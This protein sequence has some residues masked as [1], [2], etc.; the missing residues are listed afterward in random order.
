MKTITT[1]ELKKG[2]KITLRCG[3]NATMEDNKKGNIR[4]A[5]V[6]GI[7]TEMGSIYM[8]DVVLAYKGDETLCVVPTPSQKKLKQAIGSIF[9]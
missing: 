6:E 4:M 7:Y 8:S 9:G 3:W 1:N 2:D 5:T